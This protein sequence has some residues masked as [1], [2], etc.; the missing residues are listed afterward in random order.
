MGFVA[1]YA[2]SGSATTAQVNITDIDDKIIL[3]AR[4]NKL[5]KDY[6]ESNKGVDEVCGWLAI[7]VFGRH[8]SNQGWVQLDSVPGCRAVVACPAGRTGVVAPV[9]CMLCGTCHVAQVFKDVSDA[10]TAMVKK[11]E[12]KLAELKATKPAAQKEAEKHEVA[13]LEQQMKLEQAVK[14]KAAVDTAKAT[15]EALAIIEAGRDA[16]AAELDKKLGHTVTGEWPAPASRHSYARFALRVG[17][18]APAFVPESFFFLKST[19]IDQ[20]NQTRHPACPPR[21]IN[22]KTSC[23]SQS[24]RICLVARRNRSK[25]LRRAREGIRG[26]LPG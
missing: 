12:D 7:L 26:G 14:S 18:A 5:V 15:G 1:G 17:C 20:N 11:M 22:W 16:L 3:R 8:A 6:I 21:A 23:P 10:A 9:R 25:G 13:I 2:D 4:R 19:F 24:V